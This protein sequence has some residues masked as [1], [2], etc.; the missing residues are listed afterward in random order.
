MVFEIDT[1]SERLIRERVASGRYR[2]TAEVV[3]EALD[4]LAE[5]EQLKRLRALVLEGFE[6]AKNGEMVELTAELMEDLACEASERT[7]L[8]LRPDPN[9]CP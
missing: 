3:R 7:R 5:R 9:V 2:D 8:G 6:S 1:A 4:A